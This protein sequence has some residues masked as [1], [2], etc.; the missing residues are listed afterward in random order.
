MKWHPWKW[1]LGRL[2]RC[3]RADQDLDD[4]I[5]AHL[6]IDARQRMEAGDPPELARLKAAKEF[7][8]APSSGR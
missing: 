3:A 2:L 7:G 1:T 8:N 4:E 5:R 6:A